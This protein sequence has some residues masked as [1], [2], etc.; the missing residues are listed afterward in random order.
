LN[1][2]LVGSGNNWP[3]I[4]TFNVTL[5]CGSNNL[6]IVT[7]NQGAGSPAALIYG[8]VQNQTNCYN[9][10]AN[11]SAYYNRRNCRC[12]CTSICNCATRAQ[13]Y[14]GYPYCGCLCSFPRV[15]SALQYFDQAN[16]AC[17]CI[18]RLC[19]PSFYLNSRTCACICRPIRCET[20]LVQD[21]TTCL[22]VNP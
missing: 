16:C 18:P 17:R 22:C 21:P 2:A 4:Y 13:R 1:G 11:P 15:C 7:F 10:S 12:Q 14:F 5:V 19:A 20:G 6:T 3:T 9:C 8:V